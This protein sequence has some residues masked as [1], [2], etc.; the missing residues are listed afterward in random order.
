MTVHHSVLLVSSL[1]GV[2]S[3][4][5]CAAR[6]P[7]APATLA[8]VSCGGQRYLEVRNG[9]EVSVD[10]YAYTA[11]PA[12]TARFLGTVSP[13]VERL[14]VFEPLGFAYAERDGHR[15][16]GRRARGDVSFAHVCEPR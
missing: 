1:L 14:P 6:P 9:L 15:V 10:V 12:G 5:A 13:G 4:T 8:P 16:S 3:L 11:S 2:L 7:D